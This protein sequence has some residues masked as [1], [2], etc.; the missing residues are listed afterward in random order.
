MA[1][2]NP[3]K[4]LDGHCS[5]TWNGSLFVLSSDSFQSVQL[6]QGSQ[7]NQE[8]TGHAVTG[9]A[10]AK[11]QQGDDASSAQLY[12]VGGTSSESDSNYSGLQRYT[13][14]SKTWE[15]LPVPVPD[16]RD[17][18]NHTA[19]YMPQDNKILVYAGN[20]AS[21][22]A[23]LSSATF[24]ILAAAPYTV[25]SATMTGHT[26]NNPIL[27]TW[28]AT[29]VFMTGGSSI[30]ATNYLFDTTNGWTR[31]GTS[32]TAPI[33]PGIRGVVVQGTDGSKVLQTYDASVSPNRVT[34]ILLL[35]PDGSP[36]DL[37]QTLGGGPSKR[38]LSSSN[39]PAYNSTNAPAITRSDF[40]VA[41][42][43]Q[44]LV[45]LAGGNPATPISIFDQNQNSWVDTARFFNSDPSQQPL[46]AS[47]SALA[48]ASATTAPTSSAAVAAT[49]STDSSATS[50][51]TDGVPASIVDDAAAKQAQQLKTQ[52]GI[53]LGICAAIFL[54]FIVLLIYLR[55]RKK[56]QEKGTTHV[57]NGQGGRMSFADRGAS[58]MKEA[59][60]SQQAFYPNAD[61]YSHKASP[62]NSRTDLNKRGVS[63]GAYKGYTNHKQKG[64]YESTKELVEKDSGYIAEPVEMTPVH[65][66]MSLSPV[67]RKPAPAYHSERPPQ[68]P[69]TSRM[70]NVAEEDGD[71][72]KRSSGWSR[73][74][75]TSQ[76][77]DNG[78][79]L[80][81]AYQKDGTG[82]T[83]AAK[84]PAYTSVYSQAPSLPV[85]PAHI[86]STT[87]M[88]PL[89]IDFTTTLDGQRLS[90]VVSAN[91]SYSNS[92]ENLSRQADV[93]RIEKLGRTP[94]TRTTAS[95]FDDRVTMSSNA[96][97]EYYT[98]PQEA[99]TPMTMATS[100]KDHVNASDPNSRR[101]SSTYTASVYGER[102]R[103]KGGVHQSQGFFPGAGT[104]GQNK[105]ASKN[106]LTYSAAPS[107]DWGSINNENMV[108][109][110]DALST[111][112]TMH[113]NVT[114]FPEPMHDGAYTA[115]T[116][117]LSQK[118]TN[119]S[120]PV[121]NGSGMAGLTRT[122][123]HDSP[124]NMT[125][126]PRTVEIKQFS[127]IPKP[128][129]GKPAGNTDVSWVN[130]ESR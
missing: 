61:R 87:L 76:P 101:A 82:P 114:V 68:I 56:K 67:I 74:F 59:E 85:I 105:A 99:W 103:S 62:F 116:R 31:Y 36:A 112:D 26:S 3:P 21:S 83:Q 14:S 69:A 128:T 46:V 102:P 111:R 18:L 97:S 11:V 124:S 71:R 81:S 78:S 119:V 47:S 53:I 66:K 15:T 39:W 113:S 17:R 28:N 95:S 2:P 117:Q 55:Y 90:K 43:G 24:T 44:G 106:K 49:T 52:L 72:R 91:P 23:Y 79:H 30:E 126:F 75:A 57:G 64:S 104:L 41:T 94:S 122:T 25:D 109:L 123:T 86:P 33:V 8:A 6:K 51:P 98:K 63:G 9:A 7:W 89:N 92:H 45:I 34:N 121:D 29:H 58:F 77:A 118:G 10:C 22:P 110:K 20:P 13:F 73:Y 80:P 19:I 88:P 125:L 129:N 127:G 35:K 54:F 60:G 120:K 32:L 108:A 12:V 1:I 37:G 93:A 38:D 100:F 96:H 107:A 115:T 70:M 42:N 40:S 16:L 4:A 48:S 5:T 50:T 65:G 27:D 84:D 130:L